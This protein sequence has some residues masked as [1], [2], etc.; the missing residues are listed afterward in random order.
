MNPRL[1]QGTAA[2]RERWARLA[3]RERRTATVVL[4]VVGVL[5]LWL[6]ALRPAWQ[7]TRTLPIELQRLD[8]QWQRM[9]RLAAEARGL[10]GAPA[11]PAGQSAAALRASTEALGAGARLL[12]LGDRATL[13]LTDTPGDELQDWL[14]QAR[15]GARAR[16]V[17]LKLTRNP[18][19]N[20]AGSVVVALPGAAP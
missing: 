3:P 8:S 14:Q 15:E 9:Q 7:A 16:P 2:L 17:E 13:T 11:V 4:V 19:G 12:V 6:L 1:Q 5:L 20:F 10:R 18:Q